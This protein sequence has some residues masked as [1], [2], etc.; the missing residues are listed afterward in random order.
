MTVLATRALQVAL[1]GETI[2]KGVDAAFAPG[3]I[4]GVLGPNGAAK[5]TYLRALAGLV[6]PQS[7]QVLLDGVPLTSHTRKKLAAV[8][9]YVPQNAERPRGFTVGETVQMGRYPH[10]G[11]FTSHQQGDAQAL[12]EALEKTKIKHLRARL[13]ESLSG[14]EWQ[15]ALIAR[16]ICQEAKI[17]LLDEPTSALDIS[18]QHAILA[19][20][21]G[22]CHA[23]GKTAIV[24]LHDINHAA[25]Y[26]DRVL[27]MQEGQAVAHGTAGEVLGTDLLSRVYGCEIHETQT[28]SEERLFYMQ[29]R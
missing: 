9:S 7:G 28:Q 29:T 22:L 18:H 8:M 19:L 26:C 21:R 20:L 14:G 3:C 24:V 5:T 13:V 25:N 6:T 4:T 15:R 12:E 10:Q 2:V 27:L 16:A 11:L 1:G 23:E 17:L